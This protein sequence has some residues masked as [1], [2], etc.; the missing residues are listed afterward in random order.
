MLQHARACSPPA[1]LHA[2]PSA[3]QTLTTAG[4]FLRKEASSFLRKEAH[5][6]LLARRRRALAALL[7]ACATWSG[8]AGLGG[9]ENSMQGRCVLASLAPSEPARAVP[10]CM[11]SAAPLQTLRYTHST[12]QPSFTPASRTS[13]RLGCRLGR[14][15][16]CCCRLGLLLLLLLLLG[17]RRG[18]RAFI[19]GHLHH[20]CM[21]K[22]QLGM[23]LCSSCLGK[24]GVRG[25]IKHS[26]GTHAPW[27]DCSP[28]PDRLQTN[29]AAAT[30]AARAETGSTAAAQQ[31]SSSSNRRS[32]PTCHLL[33]IVVVVGAWHPPPPLHACKMSCAAG[34]R[35]HQRAPRG[36]SH[37][38]V[39]NGTTLPATSNPAAASP[40]QSQTADTA[41]KQ[42]R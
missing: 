10:S 28:G 33:S 21:G 42:A 39:D 41:H 14:R 6:G 13:R 36:H 40:G 12:A 34:T 8:V 22:R 15:L 11:T 9:T 2:A 35:G 7:A 23:S 20:L 38:T 17:W 24:L 4:S 16:G 3:G 32:C 37:P 25:E 30:A 26:T 19:V 18:G 5:D 1:R 27:P 31:R 29:T